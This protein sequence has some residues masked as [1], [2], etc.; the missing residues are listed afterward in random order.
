MHAHG[1]PQAIEDRDWL[2]QHVRKLSEA[3]ESQ[4]PMPWAVSDA[5]P[6]YIQ[7]M[8]NGIVGVEIPITRIEGK[9][10]TS[11]NRSVTDRLGI[12]AGLDEQN[13]DNSRKMSALNDR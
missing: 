11:Q 1:I 10:K 5:P 8:L 7:T 3:Q 13:D 6:D 12:V 2:L 4:R 9:W